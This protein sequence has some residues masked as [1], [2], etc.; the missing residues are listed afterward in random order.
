VAIRSSGLTQTALA[1][2][3]GKPHQSYVS[4]LLRRVKRGRPVPADICPKLEAA[5]GGRIT[6]EQLRP[7]VFGR[8]TKAASGPVAT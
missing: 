8:R 6:K 3:L 5:L 2:L 7:D 1:K 4:E